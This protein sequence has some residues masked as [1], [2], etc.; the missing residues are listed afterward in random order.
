VRGLERLSH[1]KNHEGDSVVRSGHFPLASGL[2]PETSLGTALGISHKTLNDFPFSKVTTTHISKETAKHLI[3]INN[4]QS[5]SLCQW[6]MRSM[7]KLETKCTA[8]VCVCMDYTYRGGCATR[9]ER[10][11][12]GLQIRQ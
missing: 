8:N 6:K 11:K 10:N 3:I 4:T 2:L 12:L 5:I 1:L 9:N 7:G